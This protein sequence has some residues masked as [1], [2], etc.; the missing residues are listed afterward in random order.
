[1]IYIEYLVVLKGLEPSKKNKYMSAYAWLDTRRPGVGCMCNHI[2][3]PVN[4]KQD[5]AHRHR[6]R[7]K[8]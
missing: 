1:M 2:F 6:T 5:E 8:A 7:N 4:R 3:S